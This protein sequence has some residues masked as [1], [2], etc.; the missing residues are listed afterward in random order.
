LHSTFVDKI[1]ES[2]VSV[3]PVMLIVALLH[4]TIAP[5]R[6][7][8][9][10][11]FMLGGILLIV[12]LS[13]F[14]MGADVGMVPF[15]QR[16]GSYLTHKRNLLLML[17]VVFFIGFA[18]T[19]AEPDVQVLASQVNNISPSIDR[20]RLLVMIAIGIGIFM[21]VGILRTVLRL[22]L[23]A[24][25]TFFYVLVFAAAF[26][27]EPAFVGVAFDAG[28]ATTGPI[29]VPFIMALGI[30]VAKAFQRRQG[31]DSSFG[32]VGLA[33]I[34]PIAAVACMGMLNQGGISAADLPPS[35]TEVESSVWLQFAHVFPV[36]TVDITMA[37]LPLLLLFGL[38]QLVFLRLPGQQVKRMLLGF[39]YTFVG[40]IIFMAGVHGGFI[41]AGHSLGMAL[42]GLW[43]GAALIP[44]GLVLGA[45]VVCAEPAVWV[46]TGQVE[47][48]SGGHIR[49]P[50][51]LAA[52]S[53]S[54]ALA[55]AIGMLRVLSGLP[56]MWILLP[57]YALA[58][59]LSRLC[60]PIFTAIAFDSGGVA[61]GPMSS[62]FVLAL[63]L[64]SSFA[65]GGDPTTDAFG[66]IAMI[67]MAPLITIQLLGLIFKHKESR[68]LKAR[69]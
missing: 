25:L 5:L 59:L 46:L 44:I 45:V 31:D 49:R 15:G 57:G 61:S 65:I 17:P 60:P 11:Q 67:A 19:I 21:M 34:G 48:V 6:P 14:L 22:P 38:F 16:L 58:I 9:M 56:I 7:G 3:A 36:V 39:L 33:S 12:G 35:M 64:G 54:I 27:V 51:M 2:A 69:K 8:E 1:K 24:L 42:G 26:M 53:I 13:I 50:I 47:E 40:L 66:M 30:G 10:P 18:V 4:A 20:Q 62:T 68:A 29:T 63:T 37:L 41:P 55:M 52:L 28:G 23:W 43:E 32:L